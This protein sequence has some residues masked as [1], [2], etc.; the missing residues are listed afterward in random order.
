MD[1]LNAKTSVESLYCKTLS[2]SH[3]LPRR[4]QSQNHAAQH[5]RNAY[6]IVVWFHSCSCWINNKFSI[7]TDTLKRNDIKNKVSLKK[8][9]NN[10]FRRIL[11]IFS[12]PFWGMLQFCIAYMWHKSLWRFRTCGYAS[13]HTHAHSVCSLLCSYD[14]L[15]LPYAMNYTCIN[16]TISYTCINYTISYTC[17]K[18]THAMR[19]V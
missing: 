17:N 3:T 16:Y 18:L 2:E 1:K 19:H 6:S 9:N 8:T 7:V 12:P 13:I 15:Q 5:S 14:E 10:S 4:F 11:S